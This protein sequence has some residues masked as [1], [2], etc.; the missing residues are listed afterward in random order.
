MS[1]PE[2]TSPRHFLTSVTRITDLEHGDFET[3]A[4]PRQDWATGDYIVGR[5]TGRPT[6]L[7]QV[8]LANGR[9]TA[10]LEGD[11]IVG[12]LGDRA[13][14]LEG[15]GAWAATGPNGELHAL[16]MAGLCGRATSTSPLLPNLMSLTYMGHVVRG[17]K[18][19]RMA[20]FVPDVA[21][22]HLDV[23]VILLVG[24]SMSAGKTT[25]GRLIIHEL[26]KN[27]LRIVGAKVTGAARYRDV[28]TYGDAGADA[29]IDFVDAGLPST[30]VPHKVFKSAMRYML[31]RIAALEPDVLVAEAGAS[32]L[33]PYNGDVAIDA[34]QKHVKLVALSATDPYA[35]V[36]VQTA[37]GLTPNLITGPATNT[38]AG[39]ALVEKL[40]GIP[41]LNMLDPD[42]SLPK[43]RQILRDAFPDLLVD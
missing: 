22:R 7:Y 42:T 4:L 39:I 37:F 3:Q 29:I 15:V 38:T 8:E 17:G 12:A 6:P 19:L 26:K 16:T 40:T 14:T 33:E 20:D 24:T 18:H 43:L 23:P 2:T 11:L 9:V 10:V 25:T 13:A 32:P 21:D 30:V 35:V 41:A 31:N 1:K 28:L 27:G 36:G 34:L 5:V